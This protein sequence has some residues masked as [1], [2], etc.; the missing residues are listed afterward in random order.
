MSWDFVEDA[1]DVLDKD[2]QCVYVGIA[3]NENNPGLIRIIGNTRDKRDLHNMAQ[4]MITH[5]KTENKGDDNE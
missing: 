1:L 3:F 4:A 2:S 5:I